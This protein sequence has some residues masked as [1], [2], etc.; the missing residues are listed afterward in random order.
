MGYTEMLGENNL[1]RRR[2]ID[3]GLIMFRISIS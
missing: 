1:L 3:S 2:K